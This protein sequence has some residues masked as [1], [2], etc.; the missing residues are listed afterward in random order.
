MRETFSQ[1]LARAAECIRGAKRVLIASHINPDGDT[2]GSLLALGQG[3]ERLGK[4]VVMIS[5][6]GVPQRY[7]NL[8]AAEKIVTRCDEGRDLAIAVD[9]GAVELLGEA[10][11]AFKLSKKVLH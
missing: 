3:L 8:P 5:P 10:Q 11:G 9:C 1:E 4:D 2:I 7:R 6:D